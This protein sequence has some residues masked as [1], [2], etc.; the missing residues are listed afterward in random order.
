[1]LR[2]ILTVRSAFLPGLTIEEPQ[3]WKSP[4]FCVGNN[5]GAKNAART[6]TR[7]IQIALRRRTRG[8]HQVCALTIARRLFGPASRYASAPTAS[9]VPLLAR[10]KRGPGAEQFAPAAPCAAPGH[11]RRRH[12]PLHRY[13][14]HPLAT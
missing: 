2:A 3:W 12:L 6:T 4:C 1:M 7:W 8:W 13:Q 14:H 11:A 5:G 10:L 9:R